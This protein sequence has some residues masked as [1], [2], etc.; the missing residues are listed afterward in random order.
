MHKRQQLGYFY[1]EVYQKNNLECEI[2][3]LDMWLL[4]YFVVVAKAQAK[5]VF[6]VAFCVAR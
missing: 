2:K 5:K 4:V 6:F 3:I 1:K